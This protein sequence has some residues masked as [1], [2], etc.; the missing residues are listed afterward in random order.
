VP[1]ILSFRRTCPG[2]P[3]GSLSERSINLDEV[4]SRPGKMHRPPERNDVV[5]GM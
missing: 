1:P 3:G 5:N 2:L 4:L